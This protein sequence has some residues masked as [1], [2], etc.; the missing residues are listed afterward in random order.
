MADLKAALDTD[1]KADLEAD[2]DTD[3]K[4]DLKQGQFI[5]RI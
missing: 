5:W 2:L 3:P 1:L 4:A